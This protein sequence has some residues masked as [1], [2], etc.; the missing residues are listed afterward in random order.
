[1]SLIG[2]IDTFTHQ[3]CYFGIFGERKKTVSEFRFIVYIGDGDT[4]CPD[5]KKGLKLFREGAAK[6]FIYFPVEE[7]EAK[8]KKPDPVARKL[9]RN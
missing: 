8:S 5:P 3:L 4:A 6:P 2:H 1:M 9:N 7:C